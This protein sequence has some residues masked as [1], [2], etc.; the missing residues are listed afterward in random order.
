MSAFVV[1]DTHRFV[2]NLV[3]SGFTERQAEVLAEE[4][5][6]LLTGRPAA[7]ADTG[8]ET[9]TPPAA[10]EGDIEQ[11][12]VEIKGGID[13][14]SVEMAGRIEA[15]KA[16]L[17]KWWIGALIVQAAVIVTLVRLLL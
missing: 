5:V 6:A 10:T 3:R 12:L 1:V 15:L 14:F 4:W 11:S 8:T 16:D 13:E 2:K 17:L 7:G 9:A